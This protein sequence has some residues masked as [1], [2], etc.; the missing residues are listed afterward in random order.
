MD[1]VINE[2]GLICFILGIIM[3]DVHSED[4][5]FVALPLF[6]SIAGISVKNEL[7]IID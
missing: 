6:G 4:I 1:G 7:N 5:L 3:L 2:F